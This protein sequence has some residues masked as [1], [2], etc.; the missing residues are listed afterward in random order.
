MQKQPETKGLFDSKTFWGV[1]LM[2]LASQSKK[3]FGVDLSDLLDSNFADSAAVIAG[4][5]WAIFGRISAD[6]KITDLF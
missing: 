5:V 2:V 1:L 6:K 4:A 3:L